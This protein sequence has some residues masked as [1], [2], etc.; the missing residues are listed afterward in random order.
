MPGSWF[1]SEG[2]GKLAEEGTNMFFR[3]TYAA[4]EEEAMDTA[5][6]RFGEALRKVFGVE[7]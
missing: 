2:K 7:D 4:A 6:Q 1:F 3:A 5:V